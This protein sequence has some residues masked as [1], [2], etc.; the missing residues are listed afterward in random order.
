MTYFA[1]AGRG[2]MKRYPLIIYNIVVVPFLITASVLVGYF[3]A[4]Q[5]ESFVAVFGVRMGSPWMRS[6]AISV[7]SDV[8]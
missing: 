8:F 6:L 3:A 4:S 1:N 5:K 2:I 7:Y